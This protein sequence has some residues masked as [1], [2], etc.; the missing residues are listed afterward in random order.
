MLREQLSIIPHFFNTIHNKLYPIFIKITTT[1]LIID[2]LDTKPELAL[3]LKYIW[4]S[5][6]VTK[7][8][9]QT[10]INTEVDS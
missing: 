6:V 8:N 7:N 4:L 5:D 9:R 3:L 1:I 10:N 2:A